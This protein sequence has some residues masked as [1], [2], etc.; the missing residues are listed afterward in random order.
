VVDLTFDIAMTTSRTTGPRYDMPMESQTLIRVRYAETDAMGIVHHAVYP[1]WLEL[2]RSDFLREFGQSYSEW[3]AQGVFMPL[4]ELHVRYRQPA[5][6]DELVEV[7]SHIQEANRK[8]ITFAYRV[9]R[10]K[11]RLVEATTTH[12]VTGTN[13]RSQAMPEVIWNSIEKELKSRP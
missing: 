3:E 7:F 13:G 11:T 5:R 2:G 4:S 10:G 8:K 12:L 1:V 9:M 6:Y